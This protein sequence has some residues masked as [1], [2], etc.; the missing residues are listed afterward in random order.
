MIV[1]ALTSSEVNAFL[2]A[3]SATILVILLARTLY[4]RSRDDQES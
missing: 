4:K 3:A 2:I 1:L